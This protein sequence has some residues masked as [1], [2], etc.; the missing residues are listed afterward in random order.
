MVKKTN[1]KKTNNHKH[2]FTDFFLWNSR[3]WRNSEC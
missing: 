1:K 2:S 3:R